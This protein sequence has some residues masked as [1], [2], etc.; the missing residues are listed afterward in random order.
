MRRPTF[1]ILCTGRVGSELLVSLLDSHPD[2]RCWS[3]LFSKGT[4]APDEGFV[5]S[6]EDDP[7]RYFSELAADCDASSLGFKLPRSSI[8]A[9]AAALGF[10]DDAELRVIRLT[11]ENL[12]AQV[13]S[14]ALAFKSGFWRQ[15][16]GEE[17][18][19]AE[20]HHV[21]PVRCKRALA[22]L[23]AREQELDRLAGGHPVMRLTYEQLVGGSEL[24]AV[25]RFCGVAPR[26]LSSP[27]RK[28]RTLPLREAIENW[29]ELSAELRGTRFERYLADAP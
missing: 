5:H 11:R 22:N 12:L 25:Q 21:D 1:V 20:T 19:A 14:A 29:D 2:I 6:E 23:E 15:R 27:H 3:E 13:V 28:L 9:H 18:Y 8:E 24:E 4:D 26:A 16:G 17:A 7:I 10:L